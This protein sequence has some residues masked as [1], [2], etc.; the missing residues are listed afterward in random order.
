MSTRFSLR[1][2]LHDF[3]LDELGIAY[4]LLLG[5]ACFQVVLAASP[6]RILVAHVL[7][8]DDAYY[9]FRVSRSLAAM[10]VA[11][12]D[13]LHE[14]NG[15]QLLWAGVLAVLARFVEDETL[16]LRAALALS[17]ALN[18]VAG[19]GLG[20]LGLSLHSKTLG[21][22]AIVL[23]SGMMINGRATLSGMEFPLHMAVIVAC[24]AIGCTAW[25]QPEQLGLRGMVA[26]LVL[27]SLNAWVRLD[28]ALFSVVVWL[29]LARASGRWPAGERRRAA[30][31][32]LFV[33]P[34]AAAG[35]YT[36]TSWWLGG[37]VTP[38]SGA[39]KALYADRHFSGWGP[40]VA[41]G[42]HG[43]WWVSILTR[44][45][46]AIVH[47]RLATA[48]QLQ[49]PLF[50]A[51]GIVA[52]ASLV[53]AI[54]CVA[55][56]PLGERDRWLSRA[57]LILMAV[58][59]VHA[60]VVA[61]LIGPFSHVVSRYY[62]WL[63]LSFV[64]AVGLL[65]ARSRPRPQI[66]ALACA[67]L[68]IS[69]LPSARRMLVDP[70]PNGL[71]VRRQE[72]AERIRRDL[73]PDARVGAWNAGQLGYFCGRTVVNLDGLAN[74]GEFLAF[75]R[76]QRPIREYLDREGIEYLADYDDSDLSM[77]FR[78]RWDRSR[79]FR[80]SIEWSDL[81]I[82]YSDSAPARRLYLARLVPRRSE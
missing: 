6:L 7:S 30:T 18:L 48:V 44:T 43:F 41:V 81:E 74:D 37:T 45:A 29:A 65:V 66:F 8:N 78:E 10:G 77:R 61:F 36:A 40:W 26:G 15:V 73:P 21:A 68:L 52:T 49:N 67:A 3:R 19:I 47:P 24:S 57:L 39:V 23:W 5:A 4:V 60:G 79:W 42:G 20:R 80:G 76:S 34:I 38:I 16:Y 31:A 56:P 63:T 50:L 62:G 35:A 72:L 70:L 13:G 75:L 59:A 9:Y 64:L 55:A 46:L 22:T 53:A 17:V 71:N 32:L 14:T 82:L 51:G 54:L 33:L 69:W 11:T 28:S 27:L 12:F 1:T 2:A 58:G 25:R